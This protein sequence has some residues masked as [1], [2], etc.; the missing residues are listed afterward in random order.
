MCGDHHDSNRELCA[1]GRGDEEFGKSLS[2]CTGSV[3]R[4]QKLSDMG[5][6]KN[7]YALRFQQVFFRGDVALLLIFG[8]MLG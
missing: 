2:T 5:G 1:V 4:A 7:Q 8:N 6:R 3:C